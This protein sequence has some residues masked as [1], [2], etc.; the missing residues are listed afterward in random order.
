MSSSSFGVVDVGL[1]LGGVDISLGRKNSR[2][3]AS[4]LGMHS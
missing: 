3:L 2:L 1:A 4:G